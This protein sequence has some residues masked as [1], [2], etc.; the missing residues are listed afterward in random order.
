MNLLGVNG[1]NKICE[2]VEKDGIMYLED[3]RLKKSLPYI[4]GRLKDLNTAILTS[5][6]LGELVGCISI[7]LYEYDV[8]SL[9]IRMV[10]VENRMLLA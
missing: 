7:D 3:Y 4:K 5:G 9:S 10:E 2:R 6:G 8:L 1:M